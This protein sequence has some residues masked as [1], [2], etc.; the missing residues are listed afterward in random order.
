MLKKLAVICSI[1]LFLIS[2]GAAEK[3]AVKS[4][5]ALDLS[6]I[7]AIAKQEVEKGS[8]PGAVICVVHNREI[9]YLK[10]FGNQMIEPR[11]VPMKENTI[12]DL[13]SCTKP[14]ATATCMMILADQKKLSLEDYVWKYLPDFK[15]NGKE[16][17]KIKHLMTHTS[18]LPAYTSAGAL[19]KAY[20]SPCPDQLITKICS[21]KAR[22]LPGE[23]TT[24]SCLGFITQARIIEI[25]SGKTIDQFAK[26][27]LFE[28]LSMNHSAFNPPAAW[29]SNI[30]ATQVINGKPLVGKVHDPLAGLMDGKSGNAGLFS[31]VQDL[32]LYCQ[33][34]LNKGTLFGKRIISAEAVEKLTTEQ[35]GPRA[36]GFDVNSGYAWIKGDLAPKTAFCH[37]GY[38]GTA[39]VID[40]EN[41]LFFIVL[42]NRAHPNDKGTVKAIRKGVARVVYES[43]K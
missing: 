9:A 1:L 42:T 40:P 19:K 17:V 32:M 26:E 41:D 5:Q 13:A 4:L 6:A 16:N 7:D 30:A 24:Y 39:V 35:I 43:L 14:I 11:K 36:C 34:L 31:N 12:F 18:G 38:T 33:M 22:S 23:K 2:L 3:G 37:S 28:P 10:A 25:V 27:N 29:Y 15:A 21:L 20:G 8:F